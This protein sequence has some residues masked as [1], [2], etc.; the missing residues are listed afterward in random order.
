MMKISI[1]REQNQTGLSFAE[2]ENQRSTAEGKV[3]FRPQVKQA[4]LW[5]LVAILNICGTAAFASCT[6]NDDNP[7]GQAVES[8]YIP[9]APD[10]SDPTMWITADGDADGTGAD[11]FY[12]VSTWEDDWTTA[13]GKVCHYA[14]VWNPEHRAHMADLEM[15]KVAA[16]MSPGNRFFAPFYRHTTIQAFMTNSE[17]TV[18]QRTRLSMDDVRTAFDLFQAQRDQSRP[19]II[20]GFSQGGLAVV[21]LLKHIDDET[22]SQLAAAYVLGYKVTKADMAAC[23]HIRPAEGETDAG[24][25][26]CYNTVKD[27]KYVLPLIAGS[28]ICINPVNWRTDAT[29]AT[30]H[31]TITIT[32]SPEHHVLVATNYSASEYPPF[33]GF[34]NV[35][36]I[37]SCEPWLYSECLAK[38]IKVRAKE[39]R[40]IHQPTVTLIQER[41]KLLVGTTGDYRP[42]S[43]RE[44]DG[45]YWGFGIE[46]AKK[47][48]ERIGVG[49]DY[50]QTSWPTLTADVQAEPQTF[51]LAIG[52]ITITDTRKETMLMSDGYLANGKT[53]LCR[54]TDADRYQ[55]LADIDK[56]EVR[57]MV[58]PGGL[59]EKFANENLTHATIIVY[60]KNEEIPNQVAEGNADV[61][62][63]EITEAP[64]YVQND[65]R[66]AAPLL[67]APFTHGEIGV[68]MRKGQ[69]DLLT[70]VNAVIAQMKTDGS[71]RQLHEKYGLVYGYE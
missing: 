24:V 22:Y 7:S 48:A 18:Y 31:D 50:V 60:Q 58:N 45:N 11:V 26:I 37:H 20:A 29:P 14:D 30:L 33:R 56:P 15:K 17:D 52:G 43:Y 65:P 12:V 34:L 39:W 40:K 23:S 41:G 19:L 8:R 51:D 25:T 61:M 63:T 36:D 62:I 32:V 44:A 16:Y 38:N 69:D 47:I 68:L 67:N 13:D 42:L 49:I 4:K 71:L 54:A 3:K 53:I 64:W 6:A 5:V 10:Y 46:M 28:D 35:G 27:V 70:L 9:Q 2:R 57:V 1:K 66:L 21:E 59:N 55:S